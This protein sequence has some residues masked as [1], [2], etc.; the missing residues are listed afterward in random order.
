LTFLSFGLDFDCSPLESLPTVVAVVSAVLLPVVVVVGCVSV[1]SASVSTLG[2][3]GVVGSAALD[4]R[5]IPINAF[6]DIFIKKAVEVLEDNIREAAA[7][8]C[9]ERSLE[10]MMKGDVS[11]MIRLLKQRADL[12]GGSLEV[13]VVS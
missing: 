4:A 9:K 2:S 13:T 3:T 6:D 1:S 11:S 5:R 12:E 10:A 7:E 8:E